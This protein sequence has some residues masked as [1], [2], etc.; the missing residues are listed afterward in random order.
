VAGFTLAAYPPKPRRL[1]RD[2]AVKSEFA[3]IVRQTER[4]SSI[5]IATISV[6][7]ETD[8]HQLHDPG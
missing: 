3:I 1:S 6:G 2:H 7:T 5:S 8:A 4:W